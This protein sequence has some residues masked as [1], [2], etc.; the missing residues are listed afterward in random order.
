MEAPP[1]SLSYNE[2]TTTSAAEAKEEAEAFISQNSDSADQT[3]AT[4]TSME[5]PRDHPLV[6]NLSRNPHWGRVLIILSRSALVDMVQTVPDGLNLPHSLYPRVS[7]SL[8]RTPA[9][10]FV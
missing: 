8:P 9:G 7:A 1:H 2:S 5:T 3:E 4:M 10:R 6:R